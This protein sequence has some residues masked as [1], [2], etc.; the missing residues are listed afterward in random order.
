[1]PLRRALRPTRLLLLAGLALLAPACPAA[2]QTAAP[3]MPSGRT[4]IAGDVAEAAQRFD[5]PE[6]W[7]WSVIR[8]ESGGRI[9]AV[10]PAGAQGLMQIM[11]GTWQSL[12]S[13]Y[14]LGR[15][16]FDPRDNIM[17]GTAYLRELHDRYGAPGFL[18]AYNAGPGRYEDWRDRGRPLPAETRDY[19]ARLAPALQDGRAAPALSV[20]PAATDWRDGALFVA[21]ALRTEAY[22]EPL[23]TAGARPRPDRSASLFAPVGAAGER[24]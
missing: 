9:D 13:R 7:I 14:A 4:D 16:P 2:A 19:V 21:P 22:P 12:R 24:Q 20:Q 1:M 8:A 23:P 5:M 6:G 18:A 10:S 17:A 3:V 11:P 15:D